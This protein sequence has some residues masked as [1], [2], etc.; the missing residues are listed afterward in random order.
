GPGSGWRLGAA[1]TGDYEADWQVRAE[2]AD[3]ELE[4]ARNQGS[5]GQRGLLTGAGTWLHPDVPPARPGTGSLAGVD[6]AGLPDIP[7]YL[8]NQL[9]THTNAAGR[10]VLHDL[11]AYEPNRISV[12]PEALPLDTSIGGKGVIVLPPYRS[13]V[14][15]RF[16]I[17][18][19][20]G[21]TFRLVT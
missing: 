3:L 4:A 9:I 13:G 2:A 20:R 16:P 1:T 8:E 15:A 19:I 12:D 5:S 18:K 10:A 7:V 14:V 11:R 17:Q 6:V 21:G